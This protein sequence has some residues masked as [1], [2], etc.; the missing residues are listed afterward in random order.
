MDDLRL[1]EKNTATRNSIEVALKALL[2]FASG[3]IVVVWTVPGVQDAV[4]NY[5]RDN[6]MQVG[7]VVGVP[8]VFTGLINFF[9]DWR[10][11]GVRNY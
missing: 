2:G 1:P 8:S 4:S 9:F 7:A 11:K 5:V 6:W 10:K 3:L